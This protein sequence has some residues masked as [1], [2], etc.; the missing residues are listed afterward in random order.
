M[1]Y[2]LPK[3]RIGDFKKRYRPK[4]RD[5]QAIASMRCTTA[6]GLERWLSERAEGLP[7]R[8]QSR[9]VSAPQ[10]AV[11]QIGHPGFRGNTL[12]PTN[13]YR[14]YWANACWMNCGDGF[15]RRKPEFWSESRMRE[16]CT[17]GSMSGRWK[18]GMACG[19]EPPKGKPGYPDIPLPKPPRHLSTLPAFGGLI[20][21]P[22]QRGPR[23][24]ESPRS[25]VLLQWT[26]APRIMISC[27]F[28]VAE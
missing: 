22:G 14:R 5:R 11:C 19:S 16:N 24:H 25:E 17:S 10:V 2:Y 8:G 20:G 12:P 23:K 6:Y 21:H 26:R 15:T 4:R 13:T 18:R 7:D 28:Q 9:P 1:A 3:K 27:R